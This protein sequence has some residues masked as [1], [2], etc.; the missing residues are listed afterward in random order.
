V[1]KF[2]GTIG[3]TLAIVVVMATSSAP[4]MA[5]GGGSHQDKVAFGERLA[6]E[7]SASQGSNE[8]EESHEFALTASVDLEFRVGRDVGFDIV[9]D[10]PNLA[11]WGPT[12]D[13]AEPNDQIV[14][15]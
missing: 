15:S 8:H 13:P 14:W 11:G 5:A 2:I 10:E 6:E 12:R 1:H 9:G 3:A 4:A 7:A